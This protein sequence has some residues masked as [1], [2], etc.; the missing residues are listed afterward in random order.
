VVLKAAVTVGL[1]TTIKLTV[2]LAIHPK[3]VV[4]DT[5]YVVVTV[6]DTLTGV[7]IKPP[8]FQVYD[9]AT[10][11]APVKVAVLPIHNTTGLLLAVTVGLA[12]TVNVMVFVFVQP[13][14]LAPV[15]V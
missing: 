7:P 9:A 13:E 8:G 1:A 3:A 4:P 6:G 5:E 11:P 14:A 10:A 2:A 15:T 12:F